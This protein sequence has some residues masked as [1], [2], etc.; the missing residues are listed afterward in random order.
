MAPLHHHFQKKGIHEQKIVQRFVI[1][2]IG[3][4]LLTIVTLKLR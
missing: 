4:A 1:V 2:Q 3:L